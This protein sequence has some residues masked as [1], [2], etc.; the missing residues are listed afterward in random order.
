MWRAREEFVDVIDCRCNKWNTSA[1][2]SFGCS[3]RYYAKRR[4]KPWHCEFSKQDDFPWPSHLLEFKKTDVA[5]REAFQTLTPMIIAE[6]SRWFALLSDLETA[7]ESANG[8]TLA[9]PAS[10]G[11]F[12]VPSPRHSD[13]SEKL[14]A[15]INANGGKTS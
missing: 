7:A 14:H 6:A 3:L 9:G 8:N 13:I 10:V 1:Q 11:M 15:R 12:A 2:V 5:Q 4:F